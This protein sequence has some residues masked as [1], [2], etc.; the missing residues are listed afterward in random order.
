MILQPLEIPPKSYARI[1]GGLYL[2]IAVSGGFSIGYVPSI[3]IVA[4]APAATASNLLAHVTLFQAGILGDIIVLLAEIILTAML[5]V[6]FVPISMT[7]SL[8]AAWSRIAMV[9]VMGGN[10]LLNIIPMFLLGADFLNGFDPA[11]LQAVAFAF[12][13]AHDLG[14]YIWQLFF[15]LHLLALGYMIIKSD[16]FPRILGWMMLIGAF[17]YLL[18]GIVKVIDME[19]AAVSVVIIGLLALVTIGELA[20]AFYLLIKGIKPAPTS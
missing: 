8:I 2:V 17:G 19:N 7:L 4:D 20:F 13:G 18:Q 15:G 6:L 14:V 1:A 11:A 5:Y 10:I 9:V 12:F 3:I 16:L